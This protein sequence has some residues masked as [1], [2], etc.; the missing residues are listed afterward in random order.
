MRDRRKKRIYDPLFAECPYSA[1]MPWAGLRFG[2]RSKF[3]ME[4][5]AGFYERLG[6]IKFNESTGM[7]EGVAV[8]II[9]A[10]GNTSVSNC[11][12]GFR[13]FASVVVY[14]VVSNMPVKLIL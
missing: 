13:A 10:R 9:D 7:N 11:T 6:D 1:A 8:D 3:N 4:S 5:D 12:P 14:R 2:T